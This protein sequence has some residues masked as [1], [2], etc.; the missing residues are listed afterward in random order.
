MLAEIKA[1]MIVNYG[2]EGKCIKGLITDYYL[3]QLQMVIVVLQYYVKKLK[4]A[5]NGF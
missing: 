1:T 4:E 5:K 3:N 2:R